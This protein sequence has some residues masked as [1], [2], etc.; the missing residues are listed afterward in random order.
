LNQSVNSLFS[1]LIS[2]EL[3]FKIIHQANDNT[4]HINQNNKYHHLLSVQGDNDLISAIKPINKAQKQLVKI[5]A[6]D[7]DP[8]Y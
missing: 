4:I 8:K 5:I 3:F 6:D 2:E 1:I 7:T